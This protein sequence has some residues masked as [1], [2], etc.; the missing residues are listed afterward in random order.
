[1]GSARHGRSND[2]ASREW[3]KID[4]QHLARREMEPLDNNI[5]TPDDVKGAL[6]TLHEQDP[7]LEARYREYRK[8]REQY[9]HHIRGQ[10]DKKNVK[11]SA[12]KSWK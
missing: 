7:G 11:E 12:K 10:I 5:V 4:R 8:V 2:W 3:G 6:R 1:M 9:V